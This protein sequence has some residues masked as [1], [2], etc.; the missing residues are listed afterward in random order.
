M[1]YGV[2]ALTAAL[3]LLAGVALGGAGHGWVPGSFG[4]FALAPLGF[5]AV[6]NGLSLAPSPRV[7]V[8]VLA[9]GLATF[10]IVALA[11]VVSGSE[12]FE[13]F[14]HATGAAGIAV[15]LGAYVGW[16]AIAAFVL[17]RAKRVQQHGT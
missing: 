7:A 14:L 9:S 2:A 15:G 12:P 1:R 4:C 6:L 17:V 3:L 13:R 11:T 10:S 5:L 8:V 16:L